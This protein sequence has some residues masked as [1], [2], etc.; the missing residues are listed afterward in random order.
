MNEHAPQ[1]YDPTA[2]LIEHQQ[3]ITTPPP[4][5][6]PLPPVPDRGVLRLL[7]RHFRRLAPALVTTAAWGLATAW[8][9]MLPEGATEPLWLMGTLAALAGTGG[10]IAASKRHGS[11]DAM[12]MSFAGA[13]TFGMIGV[14]AWTPHWP[15]AVLM[16]LVALAA[17][18]AACLPHWRAER[19]EGTRHDHAVELEHV[20]GYH[21]MRDT[22][23]RTAGAVEV[24]KSLHAAEVEKVR[25]IVAASDARVRDAELART[26][27]MLAPGEELDVAALLRAA[28]HDAPRELTAAERGEQR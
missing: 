26:Q 5:V 9:G 10:I 1:P 11:K 17:A 19:R 8:H 24:A 21:Q 28:G 27:R 13:G 20:R 4:G 25:A 6:A 23:T 3:Q 14:A 15:V 7:M 22:A 12:G 16:W 18:Y 2:Y